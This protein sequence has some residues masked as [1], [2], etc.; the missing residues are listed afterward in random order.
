MHFDGIGHVAEIGRN[1]DFNSFGVETEPYRVYRI[2]RDCETLH[3]DV[4]DH[5]AGTR[6]EMLDR[7]RFGVFPVD[8]GRGQARDEYGETLSFFRAGPRQPREAGD[9]IGVLV[10]DEHGVQIFGLLADFGKPARQ[11]PDAEPCV[12]QDTRP[13]CGEERRVSRAAT[14][15]YAEFYYDKSPSLCF[16][17]LGSRAQLTRLTRG[18][19]LQL[20][21]CGDKAG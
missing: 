3:G 7:R 2:V 17:R 15:Q 19:R 12:D 21:S 4:S 11:F 5:P 8:C 6:L 20:E 13:R 16:S 18:V 9:M 14:G 1:A 10:R